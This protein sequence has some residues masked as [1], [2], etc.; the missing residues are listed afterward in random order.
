MKV[1]IC[2]FPTKYITVRKLKGL[3]N[4]EDILGK[5]MVQTYRGGLANDGG[6]NGIHQE[7]L[8]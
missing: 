6:I 8:S 7:D 2:Q 3:R 5:C 4:F 1:E